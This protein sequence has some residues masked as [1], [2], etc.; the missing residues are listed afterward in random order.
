MTELQL[1]EA[2]L[3]SQPEVRLELSFRIFHPPPGRP[4][5]YAA[6]ASN[7]LD[8][9][10]LGGWIINPANIIHMVRESDAW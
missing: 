10:F 9:G 1:D 3:L 5:S 7:P 6:T 4:G 2:P 8:E